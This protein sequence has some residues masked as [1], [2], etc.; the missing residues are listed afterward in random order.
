M[1]S[2]QC[3]AARSASGNTVAFIGAGGM[4][5]P[6]AANLARTGFHIRVWN[7]TASNTAGL[8]GPGTVV[9]R[10]PA[11]ALDGAAFLITMLADDAAT[12]ETVA[13]ALWPGLLWAQ[14]ATMG[15]AA[16]N[17]LAELAH[18]ARAAYVE[19]PVLGTIGPAERAELVILVGAADCDI[20][21][22]D[23]LFT[24]MGKRVYRAGRIGDA[25]RLKLVLNLWSL[26]SITAMAEAISLAEESGVDS[27]AFLEITAGCVGLGLCPE[28]GGLDGGRSVPAA[29][30]AA[31]RA[32][33]SAARC[34]AGCWCRSVPA[35]CYISH[36]RDGGGDRRRLR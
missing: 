35:A 32:E 22:L 16:T 25:T 11:E 28:R 3:H 26:L 14:M 19:A 21:R 9:C 12:R 8:A 10:R 33:G 2:S 31:P 17:E 15:D 24:A 4:G 5:Y 29:C 13:G 1:A 27:R 18:K 34:G 30:T 7:R 36:S 23:P 6:M 20:D